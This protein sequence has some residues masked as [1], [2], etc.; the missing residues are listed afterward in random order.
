MLGGEQS[1]WQYFAKRASSRGYMVLAYDIRG[2]GASLKQNNKVSSYKKFS[3]EDWDNAIPDVGLAKRQL[4]EHGASSE[5]IFIAGASIGANIAL[6]YGDTDGDIQ[7]VI[8]LSP[9][10]TY[11]GIGLEETT[12]NN[13]RLPILLIAGDSD[14]YSAESVQKMKTWSPAYAEMRTYAGTRHG[15]DLLDNDLIMS[16]IFQWLK[17]IVK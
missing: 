13:R 7:G 9:G 2:H 1:D 14:R 4:L 11:K 15:T 3:D 12:K 8:L 6:R 10:L 17:P 5:N 16:D